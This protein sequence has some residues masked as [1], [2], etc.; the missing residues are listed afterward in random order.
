MPTPILAPLS[1]VHRPNQSLQ[2]V[3]RT[4]DQLASPAGIFSVRPH[5]DSPT[6]DHPLSLVFFTVE[7]AYE[8]LDFFHAIK[9][10]LNAFWIPSYQQDL[11][12]IGVIGAADVTFDIEQVGYTETMFS[13]DPTRRQ[14]AF[15]QPDGSFLKRSIIGAVD[16]YDGTETLTINEALGITFSQ[17]NAN[18]ICFLWYGRL[19]DD[20]APME[21]MDTDRGTME[22]TMVE[23]LNAPDGGSGD[24][25]DGFLLDGDE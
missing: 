19:N 10:A 23:L 6:T 7:E 14:I 24:S 11:T 22:L 5:A 3:E 25:A 12:P 15:M 13:S 21:W 1:A 8:F 18:G 4:V 2:K 20:V 17:N 16:N 9:G